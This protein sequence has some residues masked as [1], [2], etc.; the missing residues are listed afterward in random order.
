M[1]D[2]EAKNVAAL[3]SEYGVRVTS[4][5]DRNARRE[6]CITV[7]GASRPR[8]TWDYGTA[9]LMLVRAVIETGK[10]GWK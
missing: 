8:R 7:P 9:K 5:H 1:T 3:G 6:Y 2:M 10:V 4:S